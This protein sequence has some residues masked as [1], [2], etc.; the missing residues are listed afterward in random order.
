MKKKATTRKVVVRNSGFLA[1]V[2]DSFSGR[3]SAIRHKKIVDE[4]KSSGILD[5]L[6]G[7]NKKNASGNSL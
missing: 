7:A 1:A 4:A 6:I 5:V 2:K 3:A